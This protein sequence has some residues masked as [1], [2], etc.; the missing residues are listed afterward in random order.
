[1]PIYRVTHQYLDINNGETSKSYEGDFVDY[2]TARASADLLLVDAQ[3]LTDAYL[4]EEQLTEVN[5]IAGTAGPASNVFERIDATLDL[6]AGKKANFKYPSPA[7]A[8]FIGNALDTTAAG[9]WDNFIA[10]FS[11][12]WTVS[13]GENVSGTLRGK[14]KYVG[15]GNTNLPV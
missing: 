8:A 14:R 5:Q 6:G 3:A 4:F 2:A 13:D 15:S 10:N 12:D 9:I 1:M 11:T 7:A